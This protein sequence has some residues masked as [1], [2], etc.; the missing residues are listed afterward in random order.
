MNLKE[1][2]SLAGI[3][4]LIFLI[5]GY[6]GMRLLVL[7]DITAIRPKS[8][9]PVSDEAGYVLEAGKL[10]LFFGVSTLVMAILL[11]VS[12]YVAVIEICVCTLVLGIL[13]KRMNDRFGA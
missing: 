5:C 12:L 10:L 8:K 6:Y 4:I 1:M 3:P 13:W 7:K 2:L 11:F 9:P